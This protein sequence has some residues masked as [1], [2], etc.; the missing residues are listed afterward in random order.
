MINI[1]GTPPSPQQIAA[2]QSQIRTVV[3]I[4]LAAITGSWL[5]AILPKTSAELQ[6]MWMMMGLFAGCGLSLY[7]Y[8][9]HCWHGLSYAP[10]APEH[11][12][13]LYRLIER[14][15]VIDEYCRAVQAQQR[16]VTCCE[17]DAM[18]SFL[19]FHGRG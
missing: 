10:I 2:A 11:T 4:F 15:P 19:D 14:S 1:A 9:L 17:L 16:Q 13:T 3:V 7:L 5:V 18:M 8:S 6:Q 12:E